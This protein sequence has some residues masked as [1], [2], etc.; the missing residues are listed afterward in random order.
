MEILNHHQSKRVK[1][2][3]KVSLSV[4]DCITCLWLSSWWLY[5]FH[6]LHVILSGKPVCVRKRENIYVTLT[7]CSYIQD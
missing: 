1:I 4:N 3:A 6:P 5:V 7:V 2:S